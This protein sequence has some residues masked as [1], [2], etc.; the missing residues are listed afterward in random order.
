MGSLKGNDTLVVEVNPD[1]DHYVGMWVVLGVIISG[2]VLI[3]GISI[4]KRCINV[5]RRFE[6]LHEKWWPSYGA[7]GVSANG[8]THTIREETADTYSVNLNMDSSVTDYDSGR[9]ASKLPTLPM[10]DHAKERDV[11]RARER[12]QV[13]TIRKKQSQPQHHSAPVVSIGSSVGRSEPG[14]PNTTAQQ[15]PFN[16]A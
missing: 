5:P 7:A 6:R 11:Y 1:D 15:K 13:Y 10:P 3:A 2:V 4:W 8:V 9:L 12:V 14:F 16:S